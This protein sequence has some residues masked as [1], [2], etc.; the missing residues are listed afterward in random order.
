MEGDVWRG[1]FEGDEPERLDRWLAEQLGRPRSKVQRWI[2]DGRVGVGNT[3]PGSVKPSHSLQSGDE[4]RCQ[5]PELKPDPRVEP[6]AGP[7]RVLFEDPHLLV[8]DKPSEMAVHPGA[9]RSTGT[10]AHRLVHHYPETATVGGPGRPGIVHRLDLDTTGCLAVARTEEAYLG[11]SRSFAERA[12]DKIYLAVVHGVPDTGGTIDANIA[13]HPQDRK[14]MTV[15]AG[16]GRGGGRPAVSHFTR[17]ASAETAASALAVDIETGRTHQIRVHLKHA[18]Y[19]IVGDPVYGEA[20]W[21]GVPTRFQRP[22]RDFGRPALHAWRLAFDHPVTGDRVDVTAAVPDD[23]MEL[24]F[25]LSGS[26]SFPVP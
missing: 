11:L 6:E 5:I 9:G 15:R 19:P 16:D 8:L 4:V 24:W 21:K 26:D 7:L 13:R 23:L 14:R 22:L 17:L 10:L 25:R 3:D 2:K 12:V 1:S 20:R 18:G